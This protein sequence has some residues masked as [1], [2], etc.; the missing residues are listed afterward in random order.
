MQENKLPSGYIHRFNGPF[1]HFFIDGIE[2]ENKEIEQIRQFI[3]KEANKYHVVIRE[4]H[5]KINQN[6][7]HLRMVHEAITG[8]KSKEDILMTNLKR[9]DERIDGGIATKT[10]QWLIGEGKESGSKDPRFKALIEKL[11]ALFLK[12]HTK[13]SSQ[14][15]LSHE[16]ITLE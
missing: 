2:W 3:V 13:K 12:A 16:P 1:I 7:P 14:K 9:S 6:M 8:K 5:I 10:P 11:I 15:K 4:L